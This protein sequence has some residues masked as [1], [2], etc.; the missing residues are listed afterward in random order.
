MNNKRFKITKAGYDKLKH[1]LE[2]L[3][4]T[5]R[6]KIAKAIGEA[7]DLGDLSENTEYSSSKEKQSIIESMIT[8]LNQKMSN[9]Q[10]ID[11]EKIESSDTIDFGAI[12]YLIDDDT[13]K[14]IYY[15]LLSEYEAD[16]KKKIISIE[17]PIGLALIGK[18]VGDSV[19]IKIPIGI[20][21]YTIQKIEWGKIL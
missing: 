19:E 7:R 4:R 17:S 18:E 12:V 6:P 21:N 1:E 16:I 2:H 8:S 3:V 20:K 11:I 13:D 14:D 9:A 10:I 15:Q 5:E